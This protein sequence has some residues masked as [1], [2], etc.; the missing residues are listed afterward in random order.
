MKGENESLLKKKRTLKIILVIFHET[1][2]H[3]TP[4]SLD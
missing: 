1:V 2:I 4:I 3:F